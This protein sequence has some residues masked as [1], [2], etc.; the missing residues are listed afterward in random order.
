M[1]NLYE[2]IVKEQL[3]ARKNQDK[4]KANLLTTVLGELFR[5]TD[6]DSI[7][8]VLKKAKESATEVMSVCPKTDSRYS[9][10]EREVEII[11]D[12]MPEELPSARLELIVIG[13]KQSNPDA[14]IKDFMSYITDWC[15]THK[16]TVNRKAAASLFNSIKGA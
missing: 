4:I 6:D 8:K 14:K 13:Y 11:N 10:A 9:I 7:L 16:M 15:S 1:S 12:Y 2:V 5:K 3:D